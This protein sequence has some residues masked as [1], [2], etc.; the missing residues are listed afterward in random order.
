M[1]WKS[2]K[3]CFWKPLRFLEVKKNNKRCYDHHKGLF[4][5]LSMIKTIADEF[6]LGSIETFSKIKILFVQAAGTDF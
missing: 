2:W 4:G 1:K 6:Y 3:Y 5:S